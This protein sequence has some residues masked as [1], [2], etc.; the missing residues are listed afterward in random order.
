MLLP[1]IGR[2]EIIIPPKKPV[3][4]NEL[5]E[6][7]KSSNLLLPKKKPSQNVVNEDKNIQPLEKK[8]KKI[9]NGIIVP[10]SKPLIVKKDKAIVKK[11]ST[12]FKRYAL[13][14]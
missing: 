7:S 12:Y 2:T 8:T 5:I 14:G 10:K 6:K 9:V 1:Q 11:K 4:S 13:Y 3:I